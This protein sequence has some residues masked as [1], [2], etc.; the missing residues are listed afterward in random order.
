M[1]GQEGEQSRPTAPKVDI[2]TATIPNSGVTIPQPPPRTATTWGRSVVPAQQPMTAPGTFVSSLSHSS[3]SG[4]TPTTAGSFPFVDYYTSSLYTSSANFKGPLPSVAESI[5]IADF[6][7]NG[8]SGASPASPK[9]EHTATASNITSPSPN[10][11][12]VFRFSSDSRIEDVGNQVQR[13]EKGKETPTQKVSLLRGVV[14]QSEAVETTPQQHVFHMSPTSQSQ[15][16]STSV[17]ASVTITPSAAQQS[18][19]QRQ[20]FLVAKREYAATLGRPGQL[21]P[22]SFSDS[23]DLKG[24]VMPG[25]TFVLRA[26]YLLK[27]P[28]PE[29]AKSFLWPFWIV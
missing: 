3:T 4:K 24:E 14:A 23:L 28:K 13:D 9:T 1:K 7:A 5:P 20:Q 2:N 21:Q 22:K 18:G 29:P 19:L 26:E 16:S 15:V 8:S 25:D 11:A 17:S 12:Y 6:Y 27:T 10:S